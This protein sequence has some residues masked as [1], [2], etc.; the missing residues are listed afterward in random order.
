[1][2]AL[3]KELYTGSGKK[4]RRARQVFVLADV[5]LLCYFVAITF[6]EPSPWLLVV[7]VGIGS[8]LLAEL[9]G[10]IWIQDDKLDFLIE[11]FTVLDVIV[12][13]SLLVVPFSGNLLFLR[14]LRTL[15]LL[16][17]YHVLGE[18]KRRFEFFRRHE[19]VVFSG[20]HLLVFIFVISALVYVF[21][22]RVN[23]GIDNY[24]DA[25]YFTITTLTTTGFGDIIPVGSGGRLLAVVIMI[26]G[27]TLFL[28][29]ARAI[30]RPRK[31]DFACGQCGLSRHDPDAV[32]CKHC[33][34]VVRI[35]TEGRT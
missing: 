14:V 20:V 9:S 1:M 10:R 3:L 8:V 11:P 12:V 17:S 32:H 34:A 25:L 35:P 28:R 7:D 23:E 31:M 4:A 24:V 26:V 22:V 19:D 27:V 15:R 16:R 5:V 29:L 30:F 6:M 21:Q 13:A 18:L 33:G 2:K